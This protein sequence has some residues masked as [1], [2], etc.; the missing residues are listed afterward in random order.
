MP[1]TKDHAKAA[2]KP[3]PT[4]SPSKHHEMTS[5]EMQEC[6]TGCLACHAIC[7]Q[8]VDHCLETG[9][10]HVAQ[11]HI[12]ILLDCADLCETS[13]HLMIT[14]SPFE[15]RICALCAE[16]CR[17]CEAACRQMGDALDL[18]C[19]ESCRKCAE[20]MPHAA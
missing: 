12:R 18:K 15:G 7:L 6:I 16:A 11:R 9:G 17:A 5:A 4:G 14:Q 8:T 19:A 3:I 13:A 2:A 1:H 20:M 10:A